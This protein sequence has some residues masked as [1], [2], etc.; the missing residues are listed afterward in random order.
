MALYID[1]NPLRAGLVDDAKNYRWT[2]YSEAC[3][4]SKLARRGLCRVMEAP[5]DTWEM[6]RGELTP[7]EGR[8]AAGCSERG[9]KQ[10]RKALPVPRFPRPRYGLS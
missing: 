8:I 4:G 9:W 6:K 2:G 7:A 1:L 10:W 5:L 3:G